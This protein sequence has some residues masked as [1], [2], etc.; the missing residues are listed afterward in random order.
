MVVAARTREK[1]TR[2]A[3]QRTHTIPRGAHAVTVWVCRVLPGS[4]LRFTWF[5]V[6]LCLHCCATCYHWQLLWTDG[7]TFWHFALTDPPS[8]A[9]A[10]FPT[11][12]PLPSPL[13]GAIYGIS[14][15][16]YHMPACAPRARTHFFTGTRATAHT[17]AL[18]SRPDRTFTLPVGFDYCCYSQTRC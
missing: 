13:D 9:T 12:P 18:D 1:S 16:A 8:P 2:H 6:L 7:T 4:G 3:Q 14:P 11:I 5:A 10:A 17:R 15:N